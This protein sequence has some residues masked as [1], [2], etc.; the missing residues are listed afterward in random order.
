MEQAAISVVRF[1]IPMVPVIHMNETL[2]SLLAEIAPGSRLLATVAES[3]RPDEGEL[4]RTRGLATSSSSGHEPRE[5]NLGRREGGCL[6]GAVRFT[7]VGEPARVG[8]CHCLDCR[9]ASGSIFT[10][11]AVWPRSAYSA[12]GETSTYHGR[13]FCPACGSHVAS[14]AGD[15]AEVS[16][17]TLDDAPGDLAPQYELWVHRREGW[18]HALPWADQFDRDRNDQ[19]A[20]G[21]NYGEG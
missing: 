2:N 5:T 4:A 17:G 14:I 3:E 15:E 20:T 1:F 10:A 13:S 7:V 8:L 16:I 11:F 21:G 19:A 18:L 12:S 6:C 9:K